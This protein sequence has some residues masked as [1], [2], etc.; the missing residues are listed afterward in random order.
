MKVCRDP[1]ATGVLVIG[2][3]IFAKKLLCFYTS[4]YVMLLVYAH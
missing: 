2:V 1:Q 3:F 4:I